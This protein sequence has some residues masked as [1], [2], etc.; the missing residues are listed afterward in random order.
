MKG[1][2]LFE[3]TLPKL[4]LIGG[5][6]TAMIYGTHRNTSPLAAVN[7]Q[8]ANNPDFGKRALDW[9]AI[10]GGSLVALVVVTGLRHWGWFRSSAID[11]KR[12]AACSSASFTESDKRNV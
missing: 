11:N 8:I 2:S 9:M 1:P 4:V 12:H 7:T 5:L 10:I 3:R 6:T